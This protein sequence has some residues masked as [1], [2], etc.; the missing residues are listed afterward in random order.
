ML[1]IVPKIIKS[2]EFSSDFGSIFE[3][4]CLKA[5]SFDLLVSLSQNLHQL[6]QDKKMRDLVETVLKTFF[7]NPLW[8]NEACTSGRADDTIM[9]KVFKLRT[10]ATN[11]L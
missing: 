7:E 8:V 6:N 10:L 9:V 11:Y 2:N 4:A 3:L 5:S 1:K